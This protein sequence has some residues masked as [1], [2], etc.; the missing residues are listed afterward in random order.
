MPVSYDG[1]ISTRLARYHQLRMPNFF[2][3]QRCSKAVQAFDRLLDRPEYAD[4]WTMKWADLLRVDRDALTAA[5]TVAMTR[6]LRRQFAENR[7]YEM[8]REISSRRKAR[9]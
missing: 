2:V 4:Y 8:A 9:A 3:Q 7:P 6:W 5:G 1:H